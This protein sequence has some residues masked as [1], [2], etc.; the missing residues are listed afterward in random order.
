MHIHGSNYKYFEIKFF[1]LFLY[2]MK[3]QTQWLLCL[4]LVPL[5]RLWVNSVAL[6]VRNLFYVKSRIC[7]LFDPTRTNAKRIQKKFKTTH[8][9]GVIVE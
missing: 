1:D 3:T 8:V 6:G 2:A 9:A 7:V 5:K 4:V